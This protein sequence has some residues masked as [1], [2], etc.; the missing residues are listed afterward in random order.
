M[1]TP[2]TIT[3]EMN[4]CPECESLIKYSVEQMIKLVEAAHQ[5]TNPAELTFTD[6]HTSADDIE[7]HCYD[8]QEVLYEQQ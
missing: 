7:Q 5:G 1:T 4:G 8:V 2:T 3:F 6:L